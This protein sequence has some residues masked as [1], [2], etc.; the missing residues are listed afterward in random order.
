MKFKLKNKV[1]LVTGGS[2]GIG[3]ACIE[4]LA[5]EGCNIG[6]LA[7]NEDNFKRKNV[8]IFLKNIM[9]SVYL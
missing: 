1:A 2:E 3:L 9:L 8:F 6:M 7:R 5:L 4:S